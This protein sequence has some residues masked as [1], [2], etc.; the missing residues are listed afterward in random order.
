MSVDEITLT[1][2][3]QKP[4]YG[5]A[6]LV[7]GGLAV[8]LDLTYET[9]E[10][11]QLALE[12]LLERTKPTQ[13]VTVSVRVR[14]DVI[15]A[16][17]GP[18]DADRLRGEL[19]SVHAGELGLRRILDT[20]VDRVDL[21]ESDGEHWVELRKSVRAGRAGTSCPRARTASSSAATTSTA[22]SRPA[23]S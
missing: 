8:R 9:L 6:Y 5:V 16:R 13:D 2:P 4:F 14:D 11:L 21:A 12:G 17:V 23:S 19:D 3:H 22:T 18:I 7:L 20:V 15:E 10:D 1:L